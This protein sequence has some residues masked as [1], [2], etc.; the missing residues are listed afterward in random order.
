M[1]IGINKKVLSVFLALIAFFA[2]GVFGAK[3]FAAEG[4][5]AVTTDNYFTVY[6][7]G[8]EV[9]DEAEL[10]GNH[11]V[12]ALEGG[13]RAE[14]KRD[15]VLNDFE[16]VFAFAGKIDLIFSYDSYLATGNRAEEEGETVFN[17]EIEN[18]VSIDGTS[19]TV[20][21]E[22]K[23][24]AVENNLYTV[25][26]AVANSEES[27]Y[28]F[29]VTVNGETFDITSSE[30]LKPKMFGGNVTGSFSF[31]AGEEAAGDLSVDSI[32][33]STSDAEMK[34]D[35]VLAEGE[36]EVESAKP[37][38][39][40][41]EDFYN[42]ETDAAI[43]KRAYR[44]IDI[45]PAGYSVDETISASSFD[46]AVAEEFVNDIAFNNESSTKTLRIKTADKDVQFSVVLNAGE[47]T[48]ESYTFALR[49]VVDET[50]PAVTANAEAIASYVKALYEA[51]RATYETEDGEE[52]HYI[53][54][55]SGNYLDL[56]SMESL[57]KDGTTSYDDLDYT[58]YYRSRT[59]DWSS[60]TSFRIPV[61]SEGRYEFYVLF[62]DEDGNAM[63]QDEVV[64][65][66][67]IIEGVPV[68]FAADAAMDPADIDVTGATNY[69]FSFE[70]YDDAPIEV[71][72]PEES[73]IELA[74]K[75]ISY[76]AAEFTVL[77]NNY[78]EEY[79]LEY[80]ATE[81]GEYTAIV[82][83]DE[84]DEEEDK[85]TYDQFA[86][87]AYDGTRTFTPAETGYYRLTLTV[88]GSASPKDGSASIVIN[89]T[90]TPRRV[91]PNA[92]NWFLNNI[93]S[94][95][96]LTIGTLALIGLI[97]VLCIK[98]KDA[99][100]PAADKKESSKNGKKKQ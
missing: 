84:L 22:T 1:N 69:V 79:T 46:I 18:A 21:G 2:F 10:D 77:A 94:L 33:Q 99:E 44:N 32:A 90:N 14:F 60:T 20:N 58:V 91:V 3:A 19:V 52:E 59:S 39:L 57:V 6:D 62:E 48:E 49:G 53:R 81:G 29:V 15:L 8:G 27:G 86:K 98:P 64:K 28:S 67:D 23:T 25:R 43:V 34:Q 16:I 40:L 100:A 41:G 56:P 30:E 7:D 95:V 35:F 4:D 36:T 68:F 17:T 96:F 11:L 83:L 50:A 65:D 71:Q 24:V 12:V 80:S 54:I 92:D 31:A 5:D 26:L 85:E 13:Q 97:V 47:E 88:Y 37:V 75:G 89:A 9:G 51:T 82:P 73:D 76:T 87:Y 72:A 93:W 66:G 61:N 45:V 55:G 38:V 42:N 63:E 74:Y 78:T 70:V